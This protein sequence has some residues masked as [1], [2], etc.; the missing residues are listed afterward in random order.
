MGLES[1]SDSF[2]PMKTPKHSF[3]WQFLA[4]F[5]QSVQSERYKRTLSP[6][7]SFS[8]RQALQIPFSPSRQPGSN[9]AMLSGYPESF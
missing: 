9:S 4:V 6:T 5:W 1:H 7:V 3:F 8:F 2:M